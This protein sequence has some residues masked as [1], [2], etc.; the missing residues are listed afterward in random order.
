VLR[1]FRQKQLNLLVATSVLEEGV[2]VRQCNVVIR[3]DRP[4]DYRSF[5][6]SKGRARKEGAYYFAL[7]EEQD[8]ASFS[9]DL[10]NFD[11]I[12]QVARRW[13]LRSLC[14]VRFRSY[15]NDTIRATI[16]PPKLSTLRRPTLC[17]RRMKCS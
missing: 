14:S 12:E 3:F 6:Q 8:H 11:Q 15:S 9:Q 1:K 10:R 4:K 13:K 2:D 17:C 16:L 5:V 7:V